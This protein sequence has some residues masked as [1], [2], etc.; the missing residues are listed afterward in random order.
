D[1]W[2]L[3]A[4]LYAIL[5]GEAPHAGPDLEAQARRAA[6]VPARQRNRRAPAALEAVCARAMAPAPAE[7]YATARQLGDE[8]RRWLADEPVD[9]YREPLAGRLRRWGR[10]NRGLASGA[11]A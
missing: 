11:V 6:V 9:A 7:R 4:T 2:A 3:G 8:V 5:T 1:V 10:R